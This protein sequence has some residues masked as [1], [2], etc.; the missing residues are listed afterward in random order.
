MSLEAAPNWCRGKAD[1]F[2]TIAV[3]RIFAYNCINKQLL[4]R[5]YMANSPFLRHIAEEMYARRYAKR[6]IRDFCV[7]QVFQS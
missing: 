3:I 2:R 1:L 7:Y 5:R 4:V 6:T